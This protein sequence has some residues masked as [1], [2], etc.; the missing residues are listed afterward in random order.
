MEQWIP[1]RDQYLDELL[2]HEGLGD[3]T[4]SPICADCGVENGLYK[5]ASCCGDRITCG[6]CMVASHSM[7]PLHVI[8]VS[9]ALSFVSPI[10][11][12]QTEMERALFWEILARITRAGHSTRTFAGTTVL[13]PE[14]PD[15]PDR[16]RHQWRVSSQSSILWMCSF[17][18]RCSPA[19]SA[20]TSQV[21]SSYAHPSSNCLHICFP[22]S[23]PQDVNSK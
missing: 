17:T 22:R 16:I 4:A 23:L 12:I 18:E 15:S 20:A 21:V 19:H 2:R 6:S 14:W 11:D 13:E 1:H 10:T 5:C 8:L 9:F 7:L 3:A